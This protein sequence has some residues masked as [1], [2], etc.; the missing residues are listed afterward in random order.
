MFSE[1][2]LKKVDKDGEMQK[3]EKD[4]VKT[5][6]T[7]L[8]NNH[9]S[10]V[11]Q[12][13]RR[14]VLKNMYNLATSSEQNMVLNKGT[15][16]YER[17]M[18]DNG[19]N[20]NASRQGF[21]FETIC[22]MLIVLKCLVSLDYT[23]IMDG[24]PTALRTMDTI[25]Q[26]LSCNLSQGNN[27][28]D[29]T[30][31][32]NEIMIPFSIKYHENINTQHTDVLDL[33]VT[34]RSV[35]ENNYKIG[36]IV[37]HRDAITEHNYKDKNN[38]HKRIHDK[39]QLDRLLF[40]EHDIIQ[41]MDIFQSRFS[42][43][44]M[45]FEAFVE[46][47]DAKYFNSSR[48]QLVPK[49]H[50]EMNLIKFQQSLQTN[51]KKMYCIAHKPRSGKS[52]TLLMFCKHLLEDC[53]GY[54]KILILTSVPSTIQSYINDLN[55][56]LD[57]SDICY[58]VQENFKTISPEFRGIV[59]CSI[60]YLKTDESKKEELE[61][62]EFD[63]F[64]PDEAHLGIST[65]KT[66]DTLFTT[67]SEQDHSI[68]SQMV[69]RLNKLTVFASGTAD[70]IER[71][72]RIQKKYVYEWEIEDEAAMKSIQES[73]DLE[74]ISFMT[75][76]HGPI[77]QQCL[78]TIRLNR[79]YSKHP[80]QVLMKYSIPKNL[81]QDIANY[82]VQN[83]TTFGFS[84]GSLF[85][86]R[87]VQNKTTKKLEYSEEFEICKDNDGKDILISYFDN[88]ISNNRMRENTIMK[89]IERTQS[90]RHS[91]KSDNNHPL[92]FLVYLPT[93]TGNNTIDKLQNTILKFL[94]DNNLWTNYHVVASNSTINSAESYM[95][96]VESSLM[97]TR[98]QEKRGCILFLGN[99]G[100]V[101]ITYRDC[102]VTIS[103]D[104]GH[105]L[106][107][108]KQ[109]FSRAL[110][111]TEDGSKT[112][113]INVDMNIQRTYRYLLHMIHRHRS[114]TN[115]TKTNAEILH[116]LFEHNVFLFDPQEINNGL[117]RT[118]DIRRY[119]ENESKQMLELL[120]D[121]ALLEGLVCDDELRSFI[122]MDF[123]Q[124]IGGGEKEI[125][126]VFEGD[127]K[128]C[129]KG[130]KTSHLI[131]GPD[132][133]NTE[134]SE[135]SED[136][137]KVEELINQTY[138]MCRS[139]MFPL[140]A[141]ISRSYQLP[142]FKEIFTNTTTGELMK[143]LLENKKI[144]VK[145]NNYNIITN[146]MSAII[147]NNE[148]IVNNIREIY[149]VAPPHK[150]RDLI[151][152]HFI[153]T[154]E[155]K[156][157]N[158]EVPTPVSLVNE[159][160]D[161]V[162]LDFW[163]TPKNVFEP[164][165]G[166]GN[167]VLGIFDRFWEGLKEE[168]EDEEDRCRVILS[169]IHFADISTINVFITTE[170]M[171]CHYQN[172]CGIEPDVLVKSYVGDT[173]AVDIHNTWG[174]SNFDAVIGNPPYSTDPS[175]PN[176]KPLYDK[177]IDK[178]IIHDI[179]LFVVPSRWFVGG[180]GLDKFRDNMR[181]RKDIVFIK[182]EDDSK[183]W[184]GKNVNIEGGINYFLKDK[185]H[186]DFCRFDGVLYDL[187]KYDCVVK[188]KYHS[189]IDKVIGMPSIN[190][191]Y[192]GRFFGIE[193]NDKKLKKTGNVV[194]YVSEQKSRDRINYLETYLFNEKNTFWKVITPEAN[195]R[196]PKFGFKIIGKPNE[197]HSGSYIS[198]KVNSEE[199]SI[200]LIS[201][202]NTNFANHLL[203]IRKI[204]QH[205]NGDVCKWIPIVPLDRNWT[206]ELVC[207]H[208]GIDPIIYM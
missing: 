189:I 199:E 102:D 155:E 141:L 123:Q 81:E 134:K 5:T 91:R 12:V 28:S 84:C 190:T 67:S 71:Y 110:T 126:D 139:F 127:Q 142:D 85:A 145:K 206:D 192:M 204:S 109:R 22:Q 87:Q 15:A 205:I 172:Y 14:D 118:E 24:Q 108:Q 166:K 149:S 53:T 89:Q 32:Q 30:I 207:S 52:I 79:D 68:V 186:N 159:M 73:S 13:T 55:K 50:Q 120:D 2:E 35:Y 43:L 194:C 74:Q 65:D 47:V 151:A 193:T 104:D 124:Q 106:D 101:G 94:K 16:I 136:E 62:I 177:F 1:K 170:L 176:T 121:T 69:T 116:Y 184:F 82:N 180:K 157:G 36:L 59:F 133:E 175:K 111:E 10:F 183:K 150:V 152:K 181:K 140:L 129:E 77:F 76:R 97:E 17:I 48:K 171:K 167:F 169:C 58:E 39:I 37:K 83:G 158:A 115:S 128:E 19:N 60:Q 45:E 51:H 100:T 92:L 119:Y 72:Y 163:K 114:T 88:I 90:A 20:P 34:M 29:I 182:H 187:S 196:S 185:T 148:E 203:S 56:Y 131:D 113:G 117:A 31:N 4:M 7:E 132:E 130:G 96:F 66:K 44:E 125:N 202:L 25:Q 154:Q 86:L 99:Q 188:P 54:N 160:L 103:L 156:K 105:N 57:F 179:L 107:N 162:P 63:V 80:T 27:K 112:I 191:L 165:C 174:I 135:P 173:L 9:Q 61:R 42:T 98:Q 153:P 144:D 178:Y 161:K 40:D 49:L 46:Y 197:I 41:A 38:N 70:K 164:C 23:K 75:N 18:S 143:E 95:G 146:I 147:D 33:D 6:E 122:H 138:E 21:L 168:V 195:G 200:S 26:I 11:F 201:Y 208:L 198:F 137:E 64:F 3:E 78:E 93:H 8:A